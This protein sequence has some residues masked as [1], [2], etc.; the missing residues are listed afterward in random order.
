MVKVDPSKQTFKDDDDAP[1]EEFKVNMKQALK[2][3]SHLKIKSDGM[4]QG[5]NRQVLD[6]DGKPILDAIEAMRQSNSLNLV[7]E[8]DAL[9]LP[10]SD[11]LEKAKAKI[12]E[13]VADKEVEKQ[14]IKDKRLKKKRQQGKMT[15]ADEE[16]GE[17]M[18]ARLATPEDSDEGYVSEEKPKKKQKKDKKEKKEQKSNAKT[19]EERA[20]ELLDMDF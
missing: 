4:F 16:S 17:E 7:E 2:K 11:Y 8:S 9:R 3:A 18:E 12:K 19:A 1:P 20:L 13:N 14:R 6:K 5:K 10:Q 15:K